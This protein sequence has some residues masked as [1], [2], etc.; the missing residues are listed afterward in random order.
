MIYSTADQGFIPVGTWT[1]KDTKN[2]VATGSL[3]SQYRIRGGTVIVA[4]LS[5]DKLSG[6]IF[7]ITGSTI[8]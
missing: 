1:P 7:S 8:T 2:T 5:S 3:V 4:V 6:K